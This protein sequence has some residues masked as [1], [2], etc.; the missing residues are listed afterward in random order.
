MRNLEY[1]S[2]CILTT[3]TN[4]LTSGLDVVVEGS[5][6]RVTDGLGLHQLAAI[7]KSKLHWTF[8]VADRAFRDP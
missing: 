8:E 2:Q 5:A 4:T 6:V 3:G 1:S 7:W